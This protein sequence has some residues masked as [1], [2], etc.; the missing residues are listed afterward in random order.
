MMA[1][2]SSHI[3][4]SVTGTHAGGVA[5]SL[6]HVEEDGSRKMMFEA[7]TDAGGRLAQEIDLG[8]FD[9]DDVFELVFETGP[10]WDALNI[11]RDRAQIVRQIV[12]RLVLADHNGCYHLPVIISPNGYSCWWSS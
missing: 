12:H 6:A 7:K 10:Y 3:L 5:V 1:K 2:L 9:P 11:K 4:N 8:G